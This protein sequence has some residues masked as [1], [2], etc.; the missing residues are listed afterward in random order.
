MSERL[1][2]LL[3]YDL[4]KYNVMSFG[5]TNASASFQAWI[6]QVLEKLIDNEV[7]AFL[8]DTLIYENTIEEVQANIKRCL[9]H[10]QEA[11]LYIKLE[12][13][14]FEVKTCLI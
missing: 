9:Q 13:C 12:K 1:H 4:F 6:D 14:E 2:S 7:V 5:L 3:W 11:G 8:D 10:F